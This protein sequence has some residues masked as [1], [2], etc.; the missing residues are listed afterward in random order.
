MRACN[1][2]RVRD[3]PAGFPAYLRSAM[4]AIGIDPD[5]RGSGAELAR[6]ADL[7]ASHISRWL[8]GKQQPSIDNLRKLSPV[9]HVRMIDLLVQAG[10]LSETEGDPVA[11]AGSPTAEQAI[12]HDPGLTEREK[13]MLLAMLAE[14]RETTARTGSTAP[15]GPEPDTQE[16]RI[17]A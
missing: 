8:E 16:P 17:S 5:Q 3:S 13:R 15:H 12:M 9:L 10:H 2:S 6:R 7:P 1:L 14:A 4:R 11:A